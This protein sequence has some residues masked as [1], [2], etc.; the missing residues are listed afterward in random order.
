M[1]LIRQ[2]LMFS[3]LAVCV[4]CPLEAASPPTGLVPSENAV[5]SASPSVGDGGQPEV[6]DNESKSREAQ[7]IRTVGGQRFI[8]RPLEYP[9]QRPCE[10]GDEYRNSDLCAQWQA[11]QGSKESA[12]WAWYNLWLTLAS[13]LLLVI[14]LIYVHRG[15][16]AAVD[17]VVVATDAQNLQ[18]AEFE[19]RMRPRCA[20]IG[21]SLV[22]DW[23]AN[24]KAGSPVPMRIM[25]ENLGSTTGRHL[26]LLLDGIAFLTI[27]GTEI[28]SEERVITLAPLRAGQQREEP[29]LIEHAAA[30]SE[31]HGI[32][33]K[34]RIGSISDKV[35]DEPGL[36]FIE[37]FVWR[38]NPLHRGSPD[39][40]ER[41][42]EKDPEH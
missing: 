18:R 33:V 10:E 17:A 4:A 29:M 21:I 13:I 8:D 37:D 7:A 3:I 35:G 23:S 25:I 19:E 15:T 9:I 42:H 24:V 31:I 39:L 22:E 36:S 26:S 38:E 6:A 16:K 40:V 5:G 41:P 34:G 27:D 20:V 30:G 12:L 28:W 2:F 14:T 32:E 1:Y 11:A